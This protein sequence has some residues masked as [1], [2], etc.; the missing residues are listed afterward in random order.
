[1][2][3]HQALSGFSETDGQLFIDKLAFV[4]RSLDPD[5][6][7]AR[8]QRVL[9]IAGFPEFRLS[10]KERR[11]DV[12][13]LLKIRQTQEC[14]QFRRWLS[15][16]DS[17]TDS[18]IKNVIGGIRARVADFAGSSSGKLLRFIITLGVS[19][20]PRI[21]VVAGSVEGLADT[22]LLDKVLPRS[23]V[24]AFLSRMY[25]SLFKEP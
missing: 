4:A 20:V 25:P 5:I 23:G 15:T 22:F 13:K 2:R 18:E 8:F 19:A 14:E 6:Q 11:L 16:T 24:V 1:M 12:S 9:E 10:D 17:A 21:G 3:D 7:Q